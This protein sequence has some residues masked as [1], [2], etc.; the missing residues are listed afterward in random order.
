MEKTHEQLGVLLSHHNRVFVF[1]AVFHV[2]DYSPHNQLFSRLMRKLV[3]RLKAKYNFKRVGYLWVRE[4][5][6]RAAQ[7]YH[8]ALFLDGSKVQY[9]QGVFGL[10]VGIWEGWNQ[11]RPAFTQGRCY[12]MLKRGDAATYQSAFYHLSYYAKTNTKGNRPSHTNDYSTSRIKP[13]APN[14]KAAD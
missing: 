6:K 2:H 5:G 13:K 7:H 4:H 1:L 8:L 9:P 11:P 3:K 14:G 10:C 12:Y